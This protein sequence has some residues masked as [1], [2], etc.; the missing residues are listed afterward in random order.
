MLPET[1]S[2]AELIQKRLEAGLKG[3]YKQHL[4]K[5]RQRKQIAFDDTIGMF[6]KLKKQ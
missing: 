1:F 3:D 2:D 4:K 6:V 5:L